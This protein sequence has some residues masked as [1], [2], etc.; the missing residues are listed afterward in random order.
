VSQRGLNVEN[1]YD[2]L[3]VAKTASEAEIKKAYRKLAMQYHPDR[4]PD[5]KS[6]EEKFKKINEAY[7]VLSDADKKRQYDTVGDSRFHQQYSSED[8]FRGTDFSS[9][10]DEMGLGGRNSFFSSFFGG[11]GGGGPR[12]GGGFGQQ[13]P[14]KGQDVEFPTTIGFLD[15]FNGV[16]KPISFKLSDGTEREMTVK[17]PKGVK[18]GSKLR[19]SGRGAPSRS[20]GQPGDLF[21]IVNVLEH[22]E[23][24]RVDDNIEVT[25]SLKVSEAFLGASKA[26]NTPD[27]EKKIKIP[28]GVKAGTKVRLR[29]L[30]FP[31]AGGSTGDLYAVVDLDVKKDLNSAQM[32]AIEALAEAGL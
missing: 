14:A 28:A 24:K 21:I 13:G 9:I 4:N 22:P 17:I 1:Y 3:G 30:G 10:F 2:L 5:D 27:G 23:F 20:G 25:L 7:A 8:I 29:G 16:E 18:S 32:N 6:A 31:I 11:G 19:V 15:A 12:S 26:V